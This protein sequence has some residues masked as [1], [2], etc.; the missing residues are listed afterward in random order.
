MI[1][2]IFTQ[3]RSPR[4]DLPD[5]RASSPFKNRPVSGPDLQHARFPEYYCRP[6]ALTRRIALFFDGLLDFLE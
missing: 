1:F 3:E 2:T 5:R 6:R 4:D